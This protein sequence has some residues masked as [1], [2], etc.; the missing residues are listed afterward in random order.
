MNA[1]KLIPFFTICWWS[2]NAQRF[3]KT[4]STFG[5]V[6]RPALAFVNNRFVVADEDRDS[7][8][9]LQLGFFNPFGQK[10]FHKSYHYF[11]SKD[12]VLRISSCF[13]CL[14]GLDRGFIY[15]QTD[16]VSADSGYVRLSRLSPSLDTIHTKRHLEFQ[17][18]LPEARDLV[19]DSDSTFIISGFPFR[20]TNRNK[21][22]LW[23]AK[24]DT[25]FNP[26]WEL[27]LE[28]TNPS[29]NGGYFGNDIV[30]DR[31]GTCLVSGRANHY[32]PPTQLN[33]DHSFAARI[34]LQTGS[35]KWFHTFNEDLGSLNIAALDNNDGT[36]SFARMQ[37]LSFIP[38]SNTPE[39]TRLRLGR[40]DT[41]GRIISDT[42]SGP[43]L[44]FFQFQDLIRTKD[45]NFYAA[46]EGRLWPN[47]F[48]ITAYK[49][50][51]SGDS[52]WMR[53][54]YHLN[55]STDRNQIWAFREAPDSGFLHLGQ[56]LDF[57]NDIA[58]VRVQHFYMLKTDSYGCL[59]EGCQ[60][61]GMSEYPNL[62]RKIS[63]YPNPTKGQLCIQSQIKGEIYFKLWNA[64]GQVVRSESFR[65]QT[66]L[67]LAGI[68]PGVYYL[69]RSQDGLIIGTEKIVVGD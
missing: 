37:V 66:S 11:N 68:K 64:Q 59:Q 50:T 23:V 31:Y 2:L 13:K 7:L 63:V 53:S 27:R 17:G 16:Y 14:K 57:D 34:D 55:D 36:Y 65:G 25:A 67:N 46:G 38:T 21:Y 19:F 18:T 6:N 49:F 58:P 12:S 33:I 40:I 15:A 10:L 45:S 51:P 61:I 41:L 8:G 54:Y 44:P 52:I 62:G 56:L 39:N 48:P 28:D 26:I 22:D 4:D 30:V 32:Y 69:N 24:F 47:K 3:S 5:G 20:L 35:L 9:V 1:W 43:L 60:N 42:I 29:M